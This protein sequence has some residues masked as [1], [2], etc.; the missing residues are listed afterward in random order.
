MPTPKA[1][2]HHKGVMSMPCASKERRIGIMAAVKGI[3]SI[4]ADI[5]AATHMRTIVA[6]SRS[7]STKPITN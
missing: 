6:R 4:A 1:N 3:L 7:C 2:A 5:K